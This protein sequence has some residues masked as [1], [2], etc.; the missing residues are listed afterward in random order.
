METELTQHLSELIIKRK[1]G[2]DLNINI[3]NDLY[4]K[5]S[6]KKKSGELAKIITNPD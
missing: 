5:Y 1:E 6:R 4:K 3:K 2:T